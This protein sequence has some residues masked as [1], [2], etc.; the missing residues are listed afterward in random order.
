MADD[1]D[2]FISYAHKDNEALIEGEKGWISK[3]HRALEVRLGQLMEDQDPKI[4]RDRKLQ[5]N[6]EFSKEITGKLQKAKILV[7][8]ISP[9]Y[10]TSEWCMKE[11]R[12]FIKA[13]ENSGGINVG[14]KSRIFKIAKTYVPHQEHPDEIR[15]LLGYEFFELDKPGEKGRPH[16]FMLEKGSPYYYK[17]REKLNDVAYDICDLIKEIDDR[18]EPQVNPPKKTVY[19][20]ETTSDLNEERENIRRDLKQQGYTILP[21][22]H[23][24]YQLKD[25]NFRDSVRDYLERC[26]LSIH[27]IGKQYGLIPEGEERSIID[28][29]NELAS[30]QCKN[31]Q[32][33][34]LIWMPPDLDEIDDRQKKYITGL[35]KDP[36]RDQ[37][38]DLLNNDTLEGLKTNIQDKME[39]INKPPKKKITTT[40]PPRVYLV[41]DEEDLKD[42]K[43]LKSV[44]KVDDC[45]YTEGRFEVLHPL[46]KGSSAQCREINEDHLTLCDAMMIYYNNANEHWMQ[47]KL[48][49]IRKAPGYGR[50]KPLKASIFITGD[51]TEEKESF[52]TRE[53]KVITDYNPC[54]CESLKEIID[55]IQE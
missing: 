47:T 1:I 53:A 45:L 54:F 33:K 9:R 2:V 14:N 16:E 25:G 30:E 35:L 48:N 32:L 37:E 43:D 21:D 46:K 36:P 28:L 12:E 17:C 34:R 26:K 27:L 23:L 18:V 55:Q 44:K 42:E 19:L 51:K 15:D 40:G 8:I 29:Q 4:W 13:A 49:D 38:T 24:P 39:E 11:L 31:S 6:D 5:G 50:K 22:R 52:R 7:A 20:A 41:Y 10:L 3:F